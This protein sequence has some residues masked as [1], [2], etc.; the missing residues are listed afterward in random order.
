MAFSPTDYPYRTVVSVYDAIGNQYFH[1]SGVLV[2]PDEVLTASHVVWQTGVGAASAIVVVPAENGNVEPFGYEVATSFHYFQV[3]D[4]G[5]FISLDQTQSDFALIH[6]AS[7][8]GNTTGTMAIGSNFA[9]GVVHDTGFPASLGSDVMYDRIASV[10]VDPTYTIF[11]MPAGTIS[12]GDSGGP[13]W[14]TQNG[15]PYV[16]GTNSSTGTSASYAGQI[17][18]SMLAVIQGWITSDQQSAPPPAP[19]A[20]GASANMILR[21]A[22]GAYEIYDIGQNTILSGSLLGTVGADWKVAGL[23]DFNHDGTSDLLLRT[24]TDGTF[25]VYNIAGHAIAS[26][27]SLG[28]VGLDWQVA[29]IGDFNADGT[30]DMMLR[31]DDDGVFEV[32]NVLNN[33]IASA[34]NI[35]AVG[36]DWQV[37]GFGDFNGDGTSDMMLRNLG[38]GTF[39]LYDISNS[40]LTS[41][42]NIGAVGLDWQVAGLGDFNRDGTDDMMLRNVTSGAFEVYNISNN[43]IASASNIGAVGVDWQVAGFGDFNGDGTDDMMLRHTAD[44]TFE[45]YNIN[46][47]RLSSASNMGAVGL[48]WQVAGFGVASPHSTSSIVPSSSESVALLVQAMAAMGPTAPYA[49]P[50]PQGTQDTLAP[51]DTLA[52]AASQ[53]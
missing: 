13:L 26:A 30:S 37:A 28:A 25:E 2:A 36:T 45:A 23:G 29:G 53:S 8:V 10:T 44:G 9:G 35:G 34:A 18:A 48:D 43:H 12:A 19:S 49:S 17:T 51:I 20:S 50:L 31:H 32:Y 33:R 41:A 15:H 4:A 39:E 5:G 52:A 24:V 3:N 1:A 22:D 46:N 40:R 7:P 47:S 38:S 21:R 42:F 14:I 11:D 27:S 16:V 6:L